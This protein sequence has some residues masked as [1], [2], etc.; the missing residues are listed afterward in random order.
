[1]RWFPLSPIGC[2]D[3]VPALPEAVLFLSN[4]LD[5]RKLSKMSRGQFGVLQGMVLTLIFLSPK[6]LCVLEFYS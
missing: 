4:I 3:L 1:M 6:G 5:F 2:R